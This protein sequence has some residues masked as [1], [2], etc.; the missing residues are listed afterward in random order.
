MWFALLVG[1]EGDKYLNFVQI[2]V[3]RRLKVL[4]LQKSS[5]MIQTLKHVL[6]LAV[7][8]VFQQDSGNI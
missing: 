4:T 7:D 1:T 8:L 3:R 2:F 6:L 5:P